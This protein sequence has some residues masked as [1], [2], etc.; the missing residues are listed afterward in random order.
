MIYYLDE[1]HSTN[2]FLSEKCQCDTIPEFSVVR[3]NFQ[4]AGRGQ[5]GNSWESEPN[6]NLLF[7]IVLYPEMLAAKE[8]F[9]LSQ[10][11]SL[12]IYDVLNKYTNSI[13]IKWPN[14][15][16]WKEQKIAGILIENELMGVSIKQS[17]IGVGLNINQAE[18][19]SEAPNPVSLSCITGETYHLDSIFREIIEQLKS[20]YDLL[21]TNKTEEIKNK[22]QQALFRNEGYHLYKDETSEFLAK[23]ERIEPNGELILKKDNG[24]IKGYFFKEV[25]HVLR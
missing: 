5:R 13:H 20:Y 6:K 7:S 22:Y 4:T 18:F 19:R 25:F 2:S 24:E 14:D 12:A 11:I 23:I 21:L 9:I 16:Y 15:I 17:I 3:T 8:Q 10:M 1:I